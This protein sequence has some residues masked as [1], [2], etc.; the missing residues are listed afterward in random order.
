MLRARSRITT[1]GFH[2]QEMNSHLWKSGLGTIDHSDR[3]KRTFFPKICSFFRLAFY[4]HDQSYGD[5]FRV[6]GVTLLAMVN[7]PSVQ[8]NQG[9]STARF[10]LRI[11]MVLVL[12][13]ALGFFAY[14]HSFTARSA[15]APLASDSAS[16]F[17]QSFWSY[18]DFSSASVERTAQNGPVYS[19][20]VIPGGVSSA[21]SLQAALH[22]DPVAAA[23]YAGFQVQAARLIRLTSERRAHVSYRIGDTIYWTRQQVTLHVGE[24]LLTDGLHFARTRCGNRIAEVPA[25]PTS[26][27]EPPID[28]IDRPTFPRPPAVTG[29]ALPAPPV[30]PDGATPFLLALAP[31]PQTA[32]SGGYPLLPIIPCC[33]TVA[34]PSTGPQ[35]TPPV[36]PIGPVPPPSGPLPQPPP[37]VPPTPPATATPEPSTLLFLI[38]GLAGIAFLKLRRA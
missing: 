15:S 10:S 17:P 1:I 5:S 33:L 29:D 16:S 21:Q 8:K 32:P 25:G 34:K 14:F 19:Y 11:F 22:R 31:T 37:V 30:W 4:V 27:A 23:H 18:S 2:E 7:G 13:A 38:A 35:P 3:R 12:A 9:K 6:T 28:V 24:T 20:S 26:P 36:P